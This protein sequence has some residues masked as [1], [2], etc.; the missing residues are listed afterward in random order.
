MAINDIT[1]TSGMRS[2][3]VSL[4]STVDLLNRTQERLSSGKKVNS[5][6]DNPVS[7][8]AA[9]ALNGRAADL[10]ALKDGMGQ[11]I[12]AIQVANNGITTISTLID[13]AKGLAQ[14]ALSTTD[15]T[16]LSVIG[17]QYSTLMAQLDTVVTDANYQGVNLLNGSSDLVVNFNEDNTSSLTV[18]SIASK[19]A[20]L[21][22][23][24][25]TV[26]IT[27]SSSVSDINTTI[28]ALN[29]AKTT[30]RTT[31]GALS[32]GLS[33]IQARQDFT[34]QMVNTLTAGSDSLTLA[35]MNEE[36]ANMLMLQTRQSLGTTAL[37]LS[38][39]AAQSVLR[40]FA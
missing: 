22:I 39:Q 21:G 31:S 40:L 16:A 32:A 34:T 14:Q 6:L 17:M 11:G 36:G 33:I 3:L 27:S 23:D 9:Q 5:A 25:G 10:S 19:S 26:G 8:F 4:Q 35:D 24:T 18:K 1:L 30:L 2:N 15:T 7:F 12:Q 29:T 13:A 38:S 20:D 37:S 28:T